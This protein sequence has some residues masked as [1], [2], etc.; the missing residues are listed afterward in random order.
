MFAT[1]IRKPVVVKYLLLSWTLHKLLHKWSRYDRDS[2]FP[3]PLPPS[4][5]R[6]TQQAWP[7][8]LRS[9]KA[10][11]LRCCI[12]PRASVSLCITQSISYGLSQ[13]DILPLVNNTVVMCGGYCSDRPWNT[14]PP[15]TN[16]LVVNVQTF[17]F[18]LITAREGSKK[19]KQNKTRK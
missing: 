13:K 12:R 1:F 14:R 10:D 4:R 5:C 17:I 11:T 15:P 7:W 6:A 9:N 19:K 3:T 16:T 18:I 2:N 8:C